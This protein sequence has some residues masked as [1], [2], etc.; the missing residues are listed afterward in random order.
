MKRL[1][2][3]VSFLTLFWCTLLYSQNIR[4]EW[5]PAEPVEGDE[6][7]VLFRGA[8]LHS[9]WFISDQRDQINGNDLLLTF[10]CVDRGRGFQMITPYTVTQNWGA[11]AAGEY[12]LR[13]EQTFAILDDN[14]LI[15]AG[16]VIEHFSEIIV[17]G[18]DLDQFIIVLE[19][20]WNMASS[21]VDPEENDI[22][23]L[24]ADLIERGS[25]EMVKDG[26]GRFYSPEQN[27]NN[28]PAWDAHQG[29]LIKVTA[30]EELVF[31]GDLL[32]E[33]E[34]IP[35][36]GG[37]NIVA[38]FP[39]AAIPAPEAFENMGNNLIMAKDE[40]GR[41]YF[42]EFNFSNMGDLEQGSGYLINVRQA[43]ELI[44]NQP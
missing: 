27:F 32:P 34:R 36:V 23:A 2:S 16:N 33:D 3:V 19:D 25:L 13:V 10:T 31:S 26:R 35:I 30:D 15:I 18:G 8:F 11:L 39:E 24:F 5:T 28:I 29:Y 21:P 42:P 20:G 38:Y 43:D 4:I 40:A 14:G 37:W 44:W 9:G 17:T 12:N 6:V 1:F 7:S 22:R 41:F